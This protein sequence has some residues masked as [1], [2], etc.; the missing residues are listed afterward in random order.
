MMIDCSKAG[1]MIE[2]LQFEK[3]SWWKK[4]KLKFHLSM[5]SCCKEEQKDKPVLNKI[6][7][8]AGVEYTNQK[9]KKKEKDQIKNSVF[10]S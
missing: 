3:I 10:N 5:C 7:K 9:K 4:R 8:I 2:Q 1:E 6:I